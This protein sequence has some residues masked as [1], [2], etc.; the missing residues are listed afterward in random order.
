MLD[1]DKSDFLVDQDGRGCALFL[2]TQQHGQE[3]IDE[4]QIHVSTVVP[5]NHRLHM[6]ISAR[7]SLR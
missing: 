6:D 5:G 3:V 1:V 4:R 7:C 2:Q